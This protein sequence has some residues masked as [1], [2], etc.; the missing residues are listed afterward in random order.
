M[1][2]W[3][4][5]ILLAAAVG[6]GGTPANGGG[7]GTG[8]SG[9]AGA[10]CKFT[11]SGAVSA[12]GACTA[13]ASYDPTNASNP[14]VAFSL[15]ANGATGAEFSFGGLLSSTNNFTTGASYTEA[16]VVNAAGETVQYT[17]AAW[18]VVV[19]AVGGDPDQGSFTLGISNPGQP[20]ESNGAIAWITPHGSLAATLPAV[21][22][23]AATGTVTASATF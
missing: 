21:T 13:T 14:G 15:G 7:G 16:N 1:K 12:T 10:G 8:G 9:A 3:S 18:M 22:S 4:L 19:H 17:T 20:I 23:S 2:R 11:L 6:C 5:W